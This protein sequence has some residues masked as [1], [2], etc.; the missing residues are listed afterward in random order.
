MEKRIGTIRK[1]S[2][3][4]QGNQEFWMRFFKLDFDCN[5]SQYSNDVGFFNIL[6]HLSQIKF[7]DV[8]RYRV[9]QYSLGRVM[10]E[11]RRLQEKI[12]NGVDIK[13]PSFINELDSKENKDLLEMY[14]QIDDLAENDSITEEEY[15]KQATDYFITNKTMRNVYDVPVELVK[16]NSPLGL[17]DGK[18]LQGPCMVSA[19]S[20]EGIVEFVKKVGALNE[21]IYLG[22]RTNALSV[23]TYIHEMVHCLLDRNQGIVENYFYDEFLPE[24]M[25]KVA[26]DANDKSKD[27]RNLKIAEIIRLRDMQLSLIDLLRRDALVEE[28]YDSIKYIQSGIL[29][30]LLFDK[31]ERADQAGKE[32]ILLEVRKV[33]R[34]EEKVQSIIDAEELSVDDAEKYFR[35]I[36]G[37]IRKLDE[38]ISGD[39]EGR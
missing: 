19:G 35:K 37:Y 29:S 21:R 17:V 13:V 3:I 26:I 11:A 18:V 36:E 12:F 9:E 14:K 38:R 23:G 10:S 30:G 27:K 1:T 39:D 2:N 25:E 6:K 4:H 8:D 20:L 16:S 7:P 22:N 31:Y 15:I 24:F 34:G 5:K 33:L 32:K 28:K